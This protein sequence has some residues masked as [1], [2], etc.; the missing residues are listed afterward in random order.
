[1]KFKPTINQNSSLIAHFKRNY[2]QETLDDK[3]VRISNDALDKKNK[4]KDRIQE[5]HYEQ[6]K[7]QPKINNISRQ[8]AKSTN[9]STY[10]EEAKNKKKMQAQAAMAELQKK[11]TFSPRINSPNRFPGVASSYKQG[12]N[13]LQTIEKSREIKQKEILSIKKETE[14]EQM[15]ECTFKP[16]GLNRLHSE[17]NI[18]VKGVDRFHEIRNMVHRQ[19]ADKQEREK[20]LLYIDKT[21]EMLYSPS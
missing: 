21:R 1:L 10:S 20:K 19:K 17:G 8:L 2:S 14:V 3:L 18:I 9:V 16:K 5:E 12:Y 15:N 7:F 6:F 11:C 13:L 4:I